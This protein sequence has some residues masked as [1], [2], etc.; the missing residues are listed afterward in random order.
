VDVVKSFLK[1]LSVCLFVLVT[2]ITTA[3]PASVSAA[4]KNQISIT[5]SVKKY[6]VVVGNDA[7]STAPINGSS[8]ARVMLSLLRD[9]G[10]SSENIVFLTNAKATKQNVVN[11]LS[12]LN[13]VDTPDAEIV[14][15]FFGHGGGLG[16]ALYDSGIS[17]KEIGSLSPV[18]SQKQLIV[19]DTCGSGGAVIAGADSFSLSAPNRIVLT[20]TC[21]EIDSSIHT[22]Q[23]DLWTEGF[24]LDGIKYG[25]ADVNG[26]G[27]VSIQ[28][29]KAYHSYGLMSDNYGTAFFLP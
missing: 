29:A 11:A 13:S 19:I 1:L 22:S 15:A 16:L 24:L 20:S 5:T 10:F 25:L 14:I 4:P 27:K 6:A 3:I 26:D 17:H 12:W 18:N 28:E 21:C 8:C 2:V 23:L 9:A 7:K